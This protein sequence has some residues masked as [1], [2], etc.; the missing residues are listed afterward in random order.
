[1]LDQRRHCCNPKRL[2]LVKGGSHRILRIH[3]KL[4][5]ARSAHQ[6]STVFRRLDD[7]HIQPCLLIIAQR[8]RRK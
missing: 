7:L 1:M 4:R 5:L 2:V 8:L 3:R 6:N